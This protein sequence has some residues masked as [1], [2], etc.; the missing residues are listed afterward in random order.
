MLSELQKKVVEGITSPLQIIAGP[1]CGKTTIL[2]HKI[3]FL[4]EKNYACSSILSLSSTQES[5]D[6][7]SELLST[8]YEVSFTGKTFYSFGLELLGEYSSMLSNFPNTYTLLDESLQLLF[9]VENLELFKLKSIEVKDELMVAKECLSCV[10]KLKNFGCSLDTLEK[11]ETNIHTKIDIFSFYLKYE[12]FKKSNNYLDYGD[13]ILLVNKL[14]DDEEVLLK[15]K[16]MYSYILVDDF[17]NLTS[18]QLDLVLRMSDSNITI[19]GDPTQTIYQ[20]RGVKLSNFEIFE[21][22]KNNLQTIHLRENFRSSKNIVDQITIL[23]KEIRLNQ[24]VLESKSNT[25]G[26]VELI[27]SKNE[28]CEIGFLIETLQDHLLQGK[29]VGIL[30]RDIFELKKISE[31]LRLVNI[32]HTFSDIYSFSDSKFVS[33]IIDI[34][35][36]L[37]NPKEESIILFSL[38]EELDVR[39]E[40]LRTLSRKSSLNERSLYVALKKSKQYSENKEEEELLSTFVK[41]LSLLLDL[42]SSKLSLSNFIL[43][44]ITTFNLY[45]KALIHQHTFE[46]DSLNSFLKYSTTLFST[47][48]ISSISKLLSLLKLNTSNLKINSSTQPLVE[49]VTIHNS[50]GKEF[51]VVFLP[52]LNEKKFPGVFKRPLFETQYDQSKEAFLEEEKRLFLVAVSR[53][54]ENLYLSYVK[55]LSQNNVD[56]KKSRFLNYFDL[57]TK[58]YTRE[59]FSNLIKVDTREDNLVREINDS[60]M[61]GSFTKAKQLI[62]YLASLKS[63]KSTLNS[64]IH[65]GSMSNSAKKN[66]SFSKSV[67]DGIT[68]DPKKMV[69]SVSQLKTYEQCPK[70]YLYQYIYKIPSP[71]KHYFDFGTSMHSVLEEIQPLAK[72]LS[73]KELHLKGLSE[74]AKQWISK[75]YISA[76]Q[77]K[78]YYDKGLK[79]IK[80][81]VEREKILFSKSKTVSLEKEFWLTIEGKRIM[82]YIDR[83]EQVEGGIQILDYKTSNSMEMKSKL[84]ENIQLYVYALAL[85]KDGVTPNSMGLWYL[86]HDQI[87]TVDFDETIA[88]KIKSYLLEIISQI[89]KSDFTAK[90]TNFNCTYCDFST[91]CS[92]SLTK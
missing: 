46:V 19:F 18:S 43:K 27:E 85:S 26:L 53:A 10:L 88:E 61:D 11:L 15:I 90:P 47:A 3:G 79:I 75:S 63:T 1:G 37:E 48:N 2:S 72:T 77:E 5:A 73:S 13:I 76:E 29:S 60:L 9:F 71:S 41:N 89:E 91:I 25:L 54:K 22:E 82:G 86:I 67:G 59:F 83:I 39:S 4:L 42:K 21:K 33:Y 62:D 17:Q 52:F 58:K 40:T 66:V 69:Y 70:K 8:K 81:F 23:R 49:L 38:L 87:D 74:L 24:E 68:I 57:P 32:S 50:T 84:K 64:F 7:L 80:S 51:D 20:F 36:F 65:D 44:I 56:A 14:L 16:K 12:E 92:S 45:K 6:D 28:F 34:L 55:R 31:A 30:T 35:T 78:E